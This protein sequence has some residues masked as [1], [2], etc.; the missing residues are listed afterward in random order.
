MRYW[1]LLA[2]FLFWCSFAQVAHGAFTP[3]AQPDAAYTS[4]TTLIPIT[5]ADFA[6]TT[7]LADA[8]LTVTF[9]HT[10]TAATVPTSFNNWGSPPNTE[11]N[12]PRIIGEMTGGELALTFSRPVGTFG[13]EAESNYSGTNTITADFYNGAALVGSITQSVTTPGAPAGMAADGALLFAASTDAQFT[14]VVITFASGTP[15]VV[16]AQVRY[17]LPSTPGVA[18]PALSPTVFVV[19]A[20]LLTAAGWLLLRKRARE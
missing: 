4:S 3:I 6:T 19:L 14:S 15:G 5:I 10:L 1:P 17:S 18:A 13:V 16:L 12:S 7:S 11:S 2:A 8:F 9:D 20:L